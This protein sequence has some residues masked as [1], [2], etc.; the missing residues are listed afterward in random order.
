MTTMSDEHH[1][2]ISNKIGAKVYPTLELHLVP[3]ILRASAIISE[4]L[5]KCVKKM[6]TWNRKSVL[7]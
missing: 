5:T 6:T 3:D 4:I 1:D 2:Y 7:E